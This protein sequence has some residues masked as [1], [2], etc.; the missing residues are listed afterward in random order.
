MKTTVYLRVAKRSQPYRGSTMKFAASD[1]P[2][3]L[4]IES[5]EEFL[6]TVAFA[7][8]LDIPEKMFRQAEQV[9]AELEIHEEDVEIAAEVR[10]RE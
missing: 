7:L 9:I 8:D 3:A 5:G 4:L 6:P 1:F 10:E 2:N